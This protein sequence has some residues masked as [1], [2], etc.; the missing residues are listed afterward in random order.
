MHRTHR[1]TNVY[2][3]YTCAYILSSPTPFPHSK[4]MF[5][6]DS[7]PPPPLLCCCHNADGAGVRFAAAQVSIL[8]APTLAAPLSNP[9]PHHT[10]TQTVVRQFA[11]PFSRL[12][13]HTLSTSVRASHSTN[14]KTDSLGARTGSHC[15][16]N[17]VWRSAW[18]K[19]G[20]YIV[21]VRRWRMSP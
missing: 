21:Y 4:T 17:T 18:Q 15:A 10:H 9:D 14:T 7:T 6:N 1:H 20:A 13:H 19:C 12:L 2:K 11:L 3:R 16:A 8:F 5:C